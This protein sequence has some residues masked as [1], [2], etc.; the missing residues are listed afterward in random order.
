MWYVD[1]SQL[2][3]TINNSHVMLV[4]DSDIICQKMIEILYFGWRIRKGNQR[5]RK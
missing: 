5:S 3:R 2:S 4:D 1:A